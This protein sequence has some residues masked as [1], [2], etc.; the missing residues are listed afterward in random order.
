ME[1]KSR[2]AAAIRNLC[3]RYWIRQHESDYSIFLHYF[4]CPLIQTLIKYCQ[5]TGF[6]IQMHFSCKPR[7]SYIGILCWLI[8][9]KA[10]AALYWFLPSQQAG[11]FGNAK[12]K[13]SC[14]TAQSVSLIIF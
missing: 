13:H 14:V 2:L 9:Q 3:S 5:T 7:F 6:I 10:L 4:Q 12:Q 11:T 8:C 1:S